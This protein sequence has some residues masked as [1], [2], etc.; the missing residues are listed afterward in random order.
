M[1]GNEGNGRPVVYH[2][3]CAGGGL[4]VLIA[5][6]AVTGCAGYRLGSQSMFP[7]HVQTVHVP[8]FQSDS[9]RPELGQRLTE[10]VVKEIELRTGYKVV[11]RH[12]ADTILEGRIVSDTKRLTVQTINSDPRE[13]ELGLSVQ[14]RWINSQGQP[15]RDQ[16]MLPAPGLKADVLQDVRLVPEVGQSVASQQQIAIQRLAE[17]IVGMMEVPW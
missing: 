16:L 10:A 2:L 1:T 12:R 9:L 14:V 13:N 4:L 17:Q 15:V 7:Q 3:H 5:L 6:A 8:M 11:P